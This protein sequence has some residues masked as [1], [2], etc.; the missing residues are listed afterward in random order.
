MPFSN[1]LAL[2]PAS[3]KG[4]RFGQPKHQAIIK[5]KSFITCIL[6]TL[7]EAGINNI[8]IAKDFKTKDMLSTLRYAL[9]QLNTDI[10]A[11]FL[12]FP[13]DHPLV[14][15]STINSLC[16][17]FNQIPEIVIRPCYNGQSGHPVIIPSTLDLFKDDYE[18]GLAYIIRT[19]AK[20]IFDLPVEDKSILLNINRPGD[21][22]WT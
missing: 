4:N 9:K 11:G 2:I 15:C 21:L 7:K 3:G 22:I 16:S 19:Q 20:G 18:Q 13:V 12:I 14:Q 17:A 10:F 6:D 8:Y 1:I 5:G